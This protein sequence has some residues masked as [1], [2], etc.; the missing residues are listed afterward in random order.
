VNFKPESGWDFGKVGSGL[1]EFETAKGGSPDVISNQEYG[2]CHLHV[3]FKIPKGSNSGVY[4]QGKYEIQIFDSFGKKWYDMK[5]SDGGAIYEQWIDNAGVGGHRPLHNAFRG[6]NTWNEYDVL[7]R[8]ARF[9][10]GKMVEKPR[11]VEV[12]FNGVVIQNQFVLDG[13]TRGGSDTP[14]KPKG[15]VRLQ[16]DHGPVSYR[17]V[18]V[19]NL[20]LSKPGK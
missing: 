19:R 8:A 7:F 20:D 16:G 14:A 2:D 18:W 4:L 5:P 6:P 17:N 3:E 12:R 15:P 1:G 11:F 13:P 9:K 10:N